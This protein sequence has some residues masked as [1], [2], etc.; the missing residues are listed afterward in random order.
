[1]GCK[2]PKP[3]CQ[4]SNPEPIDAGTSLLQCSALPGGARGIG[5][6]VPGIGRVPHLSTLLFDESKLR[7][8][9]RSVAR[10]KAVER[11]TKIRWKEYDENTAINV[12]YALMPWKGKPGTVEVDLG[13]H[14]QIDEE[15]EKDGEHIFEVF[16]DKLEKGPS[17]ALQ[18]LRGQE[19]IRE[20]CLSSVQDVFREAKDL[21]AEVTAEAG[22]GIKALSTIKCASTIF[23]KTAGLVGGGVPV[24][25]I[26]LGYD[27]ALDYIKEANQGEKAALVGI[28]TQDTLVEL[29]KKGAEEYAEETAKDLANEGAAGAQKA[30]WLQKRLTE[31]EKKVTSKTTQSQLKKL[32]KDQR[33]LAQAT[34]A[35]SKAKWAPVLKGVKFVFFAQEVYSALADAKEEFDAASN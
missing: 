24:F 30:K 20:S 10:A 5:R 26:S 12:I 3:V 35:A 19:E 27:I 1:M 9:F 14:R 8:F 21:S 25:L 18:F 32:A 17:A 29:G 6:P 7:S 15:T 13:D 4:E 34:K 11:H 2:S 23:L 33:K 31:M 28:V 22:R 16:L